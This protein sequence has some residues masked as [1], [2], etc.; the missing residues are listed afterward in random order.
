VAFEHIKKVDNTLM[1]INGFL[2]FIVTLTPFPTAVLAE[3]F[4][5][6]SRFALGLFGLNYLF[7]SIT[8][9]AICSYAYKK[10]FVD[11][12]HKPFYKSYKLLYRYAIY[13][14]VIAFLFCFISIAISILMYC[15]LF[16]I[17]ASPKSFASKLHKHR[18]LNKSK[19]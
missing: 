3:Y 6:E 10:N 12:E 5:K 18:I 13:Y 15:I 11:E 14:N 16:I 17:F 7:I 2:L 1:W 8:A 9:D 4:E 19:P